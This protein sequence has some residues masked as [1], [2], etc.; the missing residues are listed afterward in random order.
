MVN[1]TSNLGTGKIYIMALKFIRLVIN[2]DVS[3]HRFK[4][5]IL[6][7]YTQVCSI[8]GFFL[9]L[10]PVDRSY[11]LTAYTYQHFY[12]QLEKRKGHV[13]VECLAIII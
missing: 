12:F 8:T 7:F 5:V 6:F 13:Y 3:R 9:N 1:K 11:E 10:N 4:H 2:F